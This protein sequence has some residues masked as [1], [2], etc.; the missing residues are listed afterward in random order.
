MKLIMALLNLESLQ[1]TIEKS[2]NSA[3]EILPSEDKST[4][5]IVHNV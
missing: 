4:R 3:A 1:Y 5:T 2:H